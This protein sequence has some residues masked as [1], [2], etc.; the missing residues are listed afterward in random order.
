MGRR[1]FHQAVQSNR[2]MM[3]IHKDKCFSFAN[4]VGKIVVVDPDS[5]VA[6]EPVPGYSPLITQY[7]Q[8]D[9]DLCGHEPPTNRADAIVEAA[10]SIK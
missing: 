5:V 1:I 3:C 7:H 6:T 10:N 9:L 4:K 2:F 8:G